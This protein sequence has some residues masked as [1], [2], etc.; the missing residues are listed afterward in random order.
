MEAAVGESWVWS[1]VGVG[2]IAGGV[3]AQEGAASL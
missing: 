3:Q 1:G 2:N